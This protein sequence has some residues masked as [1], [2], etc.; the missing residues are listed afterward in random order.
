LLR[1]GQPIEV[2]SGTLR[3]GHAALVVAVLALAACGGQGAGSDTTPSA[4]DS[5]TATGETLE[6]AAG[7][8]Q[9]V[10]EAYKDASDQGVLILRDGV[11]RLLRERGA[12]ATAL[13][14]GDVDEAR[15][16]LD[17]FID[18]AQSVTAGSA[19]FDRARRMAIT[20]QSKCEGEAQGEGVV[21]GC[22]SEV[23]QAYGAAATQ[24]DKALDKPMA[25]VLF[26]LQEVIA[27]GNSGDVEGVHR[28]NRTLTKGLDRLI[29]QAGRFARLAGAAS[30]E[31]ERCAE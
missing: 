7:C 17:R 5:L 9:A 19:E 13:N 3:R 12:F 15:Q 18:E 4:T 31:D 25:I 26:G 20:E 8:W 1:R 14:A 27:A 2:T 24:A 16:A 29:P 23:A 6:G 11:A 22:W 28:A 21:A 10:G 30:A